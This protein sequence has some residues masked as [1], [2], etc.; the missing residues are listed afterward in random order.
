ML[1]EYSLREIHTIAGLIVSENVVIFLIFSL[2]L[3][4]PQNTSDVT[5]MEY[6]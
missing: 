6:P 4:H 5:L 2:H 1:K 3:L